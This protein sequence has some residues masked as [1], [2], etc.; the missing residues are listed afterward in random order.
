MNKSVRVACLQMNSTAS[1]MQ[2]LDF[3]EQ[4]VCQAKD[5]GVQLLL[6]PENFAQMP[7]TSAGLHIEDTTTTVVQ[8]FLADLSQKTKLHI[9]YLI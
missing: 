7:K 3:V 1:V 9:V 2:N 8:N 4:S 5:K 6:L